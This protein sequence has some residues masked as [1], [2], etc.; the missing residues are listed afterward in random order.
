MRIKQLILCLICLGPSLLPADSLSYY[1]VYFRDK[2]HAAYHL[3]R[4]ETFLSRAALDRRI[5][6]GIAVLEKDIPVY[7][8][9][10]HALSRIEGVEVINSSR[11]LNAAEISC[12][13][14]SG[15]S[16]KLG[17]LDFISETTYLG[18]KKI[19]PAP[20]REW[21]DSVY[22]KRANELKR[23]K[24]TCNPEWF[25]DKGYGVSYRHHRVIGVPGLHK[26]MQNK[27]GLHIACLDAGF[28]KAYRVRG[29]EDL[30]DSETVVRDF[31]DYD[32]SVWE[33]DQHGCNV[34]G[35]MKVFNPGQ[36]IGSAPFARYT[37]LRTEDAG[38][39]TPTEEANW[40]F[41]AEFA[42]S[43]GADVIAASVGYHVFDDPR[44]SHTHAQLDGKSSLIARAANEAVARGMAVICSAGNE[45]NGK[46]KKIGTPAD[47]AGVLAIGACDDEGFHAVFSSVGP[48]ADGRVKP[49]FCAPGLRLSIASASGFYLGSGTSYSAPLFAGAFACLMSEFPDKTIQQLQEAIRFSASHSHFPDSAMGYGIPD[50]HLA[51]AFLKS[52]DSNRHADVYWTPEYGIF[53]KDLI[54]HFRSSAAQ[55]L[56]LTV[57][58]SSGKQ[59][60]ILYRERFRLNAGEWLRSDALMELALQKQRKR[61]RKELKTLVL[62]AR[63]PNSEYTRSIR[64]K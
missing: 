11:W 18:R 27:T 34:L 8:P 52:T 22:F 35:F 21:P 43:L 7:K 55:T 26:Q 30:L 9:Y 37:L 28:Y 2:P 62:T 49:D 23:L 17:A 19:R 51:Y 63:T 38:S 61:R 31:V 54:L 20:A 24:L 40:L 3:N 64:L 46:W 5:K 60:R 1:L 14:D 13:Q 58:G 15:L 39:E 36:F 47:A 57:R 6:K 4:P 44:L 53:Y 50:F 10:L 16:V 29:M 56:I 42:D 41:A 48:S 32:G 25:T 33:D 45:G 59:Q 12:T